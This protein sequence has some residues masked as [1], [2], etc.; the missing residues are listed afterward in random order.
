MSTILEWAR[1]SREVSGQYYVL[2]APIEGEEKENNG[3]PAATSDGYDHLP[4]INGTNNGVSGTN[5]TTLTDNNV[6]VSKTV[7][8][9]APIY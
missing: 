1:R 9:D 3:V 5:G 4:P 2:E 6:C 7:Y 8:G